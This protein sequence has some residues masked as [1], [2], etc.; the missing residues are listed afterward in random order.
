MV[1]G[2]SLQAFIMS[3]VSISTINSSPL[4]K[5]LSAQIK[6][7]FVNFRNFLSVVSNSSWEEVFTQLM[8]WA[9]GYNVMAT[10]YGPS[11]YIGEVRWYLCDTILSALS[12]LTIEDSLVE[13]NL[14]IAVAISTVFSL[15]KGDI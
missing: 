2:V 11:A 15:W 5:D 4:Q 13:T 8:N 14:R 1:E 7:G 6:N 10:S 3:N 9:C 12:R